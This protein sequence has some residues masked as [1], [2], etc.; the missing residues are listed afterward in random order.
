MKRFIKNLNKKHL[1]LFVLLGLVSYFFV[2]GILPKHLSLTKVEPT[3]MFNTYFLN[4]SFIDTPRSWYENLRF[5]VSKILGISLNMDWYDLCLTNNTNPPTIIG[6]LILPIGRNVT[7]TEINAWKS[8]VSGQS[9]LEDSI[10]QVFTNKLFAGPNGIPTC[11]R[12]SPADNG[13]IYS[14]LIYYLEANRPI[15]MNVGQEL[16]IIPMPDGHDIDLGSSSF[17]FKTNGVALWVKRFILFSALS[18]LYLL[19]LNIGSLIYKK[20]KES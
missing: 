15:T 6:K 11:M 18:A 19:F 7:L 5:I 12:I 9:Q 2:L 13:F 17:E 3:Q 10:S 20:H 14:G 1:A 8:R 4:E 16:K